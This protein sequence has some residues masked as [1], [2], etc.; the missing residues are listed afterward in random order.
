M[1]KDPLLTIAQIAAREGLPEWKVRS[2]TR[3]RGAER[4]PHYKAGGLMVRASE[5]QRWLESRRRG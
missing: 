5:Y 3:A 4:M 2:W 1:S